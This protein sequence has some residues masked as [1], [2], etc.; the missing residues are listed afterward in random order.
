M[1]YNR[2]DIVIIPFP[3]ILSEGQKNQ[4][5]RPTLVISDMNIDR[6]YNDLIL[7]IIT[8][9]VPDDLKETEMILEATAENGLAKRS[10]LRL[11]F[12]MTIPS[13]FV[14]R[15]I[16]QLTTQEME[17]V[18]RKISISLGLLK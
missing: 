4:K 7:A 9:Q 2:G 17:E 14:S 6:R 5:A 3:F 8:S 18:D 10:N 13:R 11:G 15:K 16:G 12:F 1:S